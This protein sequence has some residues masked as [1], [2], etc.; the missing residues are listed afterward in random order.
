MK[1]YICPKNEFNMFVRSHRNLVRSFK[2]NLYEICKKIERSLLE[3]C[4]KFV[5]KKFVC[6]KFVCKKFARSLQEVCKK[7][8]RSL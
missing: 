3:V 7:F 6:K 8:A 2:I 5:C 4:K 1:M